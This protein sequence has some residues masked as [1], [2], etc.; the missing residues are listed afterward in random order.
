M[1]VRVELNREKL[2]QIRE[3]NSLTQEE[4]AE[5]SEISDRHLRNIETVSTMPSAKVLCRICH[6]LNITMDELMT[7]YNE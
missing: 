1:S 6:V 4:L 2:R 5:L 3:Q 7:T